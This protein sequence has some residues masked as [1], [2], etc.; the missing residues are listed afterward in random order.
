MKCHFPKSKGEFTPLLFAAQQG[1]LDS[2]RILLEAGLRIK[3]RPPHSQRF[4]LYVSIR[5]I[6]DLPLKERLSS[7]LPSLGMGSDSSPSPYNH[8]C[9]Y[10]VVLSSFFHKTAFY[11]G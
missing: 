5:R 6:V 10:G 9:G 2:A 8:P 3:T 7:P 1:D 4:I 11:A